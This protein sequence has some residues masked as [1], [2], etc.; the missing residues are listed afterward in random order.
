[1]K[2]LKI[3]IPII[4]IGYLWHSCEEHEEYM[5]DNYRDIRVIEKPVDS[6]SAYDVYKL[7]QYGKDL[8]RVVLCAS[9]DVN[10]N[11]PL[12]HEPTD[13]MEAVNIND[14]YL[15]TN[16][17]LVVVLPNDIEYELGYWFRDRELSVHKLTDDTVIEITIHSGNTD[18]SRKN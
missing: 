13:I 11:K 2:F 3:V 5:Q 14:I 17:E 16:N 9:F 12:C 8:Y 15:N 6:R 1:M 7:T 18:K 4:V 10:P